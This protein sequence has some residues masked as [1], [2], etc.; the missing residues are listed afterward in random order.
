M[1]RASQ[2][3]KGALTAEKILDA[4]E[5]LFAQRGYDGTSL[6]EIA[7]QVGIHEPG[8]Y[9]H[10]KGK[11]ALYA[12]VLD[13][14]LTPMLEAMRESMQRPEPREAY[15]ALPGVMTDRLAAHPRMAALFHQALQ[16]DGESV[17]GRLI[18]EWLD[19]LFSQGMATLD[20][21]GSEGLDRQDLAIRMIA[22]FN[23][24][25][26]Y[27]MSQR[28]FSGLVDDDDDLADPANIARQKKL[29][30]QFVGSVLND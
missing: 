1:P 11:Q 13:R 15:A 30:R 8:I 23:L 6:R 27:F 12:A 2:K 24:T 28:I 17:G 14:A 29:L 9:N 5:S 16:S 19:R 25:T 21:V 7:R 22:M 18:Q 4:A 20:S 10:F 26:G 3:S